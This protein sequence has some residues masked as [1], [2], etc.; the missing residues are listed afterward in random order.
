[1][2][3]LWALLK[4]GKVE[5]IDG[6]Q[7]LERILRPTLRYLLVHPPY[8]V[9]ANE[10]VRHIYPSEAV[11]FT[12]CHKNLWLEWTWRQGREAALIYR[13]DASEVKLPNNARHRI[14]IDHFLEYEGT[15]VLMGHFLT[16]VDAMG[17][18]LAPQ[19][20]IGRE[21]DLEALDLRFLMVEEVITV[22]NTRGTRIEPQLERSKAEV[23]KPNRAPHS[24]WHTIQ[25]PKF[26]GPPLTDA[27]VSRQIL[28]RRQHWVRAHR[29]DYRQGAG[30]F[31]RVKALV[32][33]PE[34]Q[35]GN[36]ELGTVRQSF[37]VGPLDPGPVGS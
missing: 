7:D 36:P 24:V 33:V 13:Q 15:A 20:S 23:V 21:D 25:L 29:K 9:D 14:H 31:G 28:E 8:L 3:S 12:P 10:I 37:E 35:R 2:A 27:E 5:A 32:W 1:M 22:M 6:Y 16:F 11:D 19:S 4:K 17:I 30:M 34:H 18:P 26:Q